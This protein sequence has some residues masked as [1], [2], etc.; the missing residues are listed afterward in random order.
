MKNLILISVLVL[1]TISSL[2][3]QNVNDKVFDGVN[4]ENPKINNKLLQDLI[5]EKLNNYINS[6]GISSLSYDEATYK[7]A[8]YQSRFVN[9]YLKLRTF[10]TDEEP[11][12]GVVLKTKQDRLDYFSDEEGVGRRKYKDLFCS[13]CLNCSLMDWYNMTYDE[14]SDNFIERFIKNSE[15]DILNILSES[16]YLGVS[17]DFNI[18][19]GETINGSGIYLFTITTV[20]SLDS[21][22]SL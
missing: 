6:Q 1:T 3:S 18:T 2:F 20:T 17:V 9:K 22:D 21:S 8:R 16:K 5:F 13:Y 10:S 14:I 12:D 7:S 19:E 4:L 11:V 15:P